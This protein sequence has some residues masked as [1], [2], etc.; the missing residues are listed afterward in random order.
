[1]KQQRIA[2]IA[3]Q[4]SGEPITL[5]HHYIDKEWMKVAFT[6]LRKESAPGIDAQTVLE[7]STNLEENITSL[8]GKA[9][10]GKYKAPPVRRVEIPKPGS[11]EKR[12]IGIPTTEDKILQKA[13][14]MALEP[15]YEQEFYEFSFGFR[16][17]KSAHQALEYLW[18]GIMDRNIRWI[19]DLDIRKFF[20]TVQ[21]GILRELFHIRVRDGVITRLV[22]KWLNAGVMKNGRLSYRE[23]GTPQGGVISPLLSNIYLHE[24][25]DKWYAEDIRNK[26][27]GRSIMVRYADDVIMGFEKQEDAEEM[28]KAIRDRLEKFGLQLHPEKTKIVPFGKPKSKNDIDIRQENGNGPKPGSFDF[29]GFSHFWAKSYRGYWA[30]RRKTAGKKLREK[31]KK[32]NQWCKQY[33]HTQPEYQYEKLCQKLNGHYAYYGITGN[34]QSLQL[35]RYQVRRIWKRWLSRRSWKGYKL[36]WERYGEMLKH[37]FPLPMPRI[38]HSVYGK[39]GLA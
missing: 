15:I 33:R 24:A 6:Q 5:L 22:G 34:W 38:V 36:N 31:L 29:L 39:R 30:V 16:P 35:F 37:H 18:K 23:E 11:T 26:L 4:H 3:K 14:V 27:K 17:G 2:Q 19:L 28:L 13:V 1:M 25:L 20:D 7:Y 21:H 10:S 9:K 8:L 32:M 12:P